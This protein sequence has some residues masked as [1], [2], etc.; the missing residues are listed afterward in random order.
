M[1][2]FKKAR[3]FY[4]SG[5]LKREGISDSTDGLYRIRFCAD[6]ADSVPNVKAIVEGI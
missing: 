2:G 5:R 4:N 6:A 1:I 3:E